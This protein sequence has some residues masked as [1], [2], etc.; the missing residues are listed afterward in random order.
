MRMAARLGD[1][2]AILLERD[3][4]SEAYIRHIVREG[5]MMMPPFRH[6]EITP[7]DLDMLIYYIL[8]NTKLDSN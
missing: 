1:E 7:E 4:L 5:L 2:G 6:T 3:D 8:N